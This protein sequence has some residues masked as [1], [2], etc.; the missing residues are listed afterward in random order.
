[1]E[2]FLYSEKNNLLKINR[3][4]ENIKLNKEYQLPPH[5]SV[6]IKKNFKKNQV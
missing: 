6:F 2:I 4:W 3:I 1:M 5:T